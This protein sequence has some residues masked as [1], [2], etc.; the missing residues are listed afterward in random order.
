MKYFKRGIMGILAV[1]VVTLGFSYLWQQ[2]TTTSRTN[3]TAQRVARHEMVKAQA[4]AKTKQTKAK[5]INWRKPS[6]KKPYPNLK[7]YPHAHLLVKTSRQ[8]VYV[9]AGKKVLYTMYCSTGKGRY[10]TPTG[11]FHIQAE[12]GKS[13]FNWNSGEGGRYWVSWKGHGIYLFHTVPINSKGHYIKKEAK[14]LGKSAAS[15]GCVRLSVSDAKWVYNHVPYGMK[16]IIH[17]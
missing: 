4:K 15:H 14:H 11:T 1:L 13:F 10:K 16:V 17:K 12:R 6:E 7:K 3:Q 9:M 2:L 5:A 8:R